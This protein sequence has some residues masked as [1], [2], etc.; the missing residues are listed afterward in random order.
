MDILS[1]PFPFYHASYRRPFD[2]EKSIS[3]KEKEIIIFAVPR[4]ESETRLHPS[5]D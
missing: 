5:G 2:K 1:G 3:K 4:F